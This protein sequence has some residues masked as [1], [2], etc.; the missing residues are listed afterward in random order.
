MTISLL[1][2]VV[3]LQLALVAVLVAVWKCVRSP[4]D[5]SPRLDSLERG[6]ERGE[7]LLREELGRNREETGVQIS[8]LREALS[9]RFQTFNDSVIRQM[10]DQAGVQTG[11]LDKLT[12]GLEQKLEALQQKVDE[13]LTRIQQDNAVR[14]EEMRKTVD[15]KLQGTLEKRLGES[16]RLVTEQL[17]QVHAG[18]GEMQTLASG[19]G[20]L[21]KVLTNVKTRGL[22]GEMQLGAL[23]EQV[24]APEQYTQNFRVRPD[25]NEVVEFA[26]RLPGRGDGEDVPVWLPIDA[27][28]PREDYERLIDASERGDSAAVQDAAQKIEQRIRQEAKDIS[29]K[30]IVPP[31]T[32]DFAILFLPVEGLY[33]EVLRRPGLV[34]AL[35]RLYR[36]NL[37]G[38][39][40]L[41]A[42]L[43]SLQM[44]FRTLAIQKR[45][46][47]V[48]QLLAA[49]KTEF[50][51]FG[52]V[53][54]GVQRKL[55]E[56]SNS[57]E[58]N[59]LQRTRA[60]N[61]RL[62]SVQDL[63]NTVLPPLMEGTLAETEPDT[64]VP[65]DGSAAGG[66]V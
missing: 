21:K 22:W 62:R 12:Q 14:L 43:N 31:L 20:D 40:T 58:K 44:G 65:S 8:A 10:A 42:L 23:L 13:K 16:F 57:I 17:K 30:Y 66:D 39:T 47:E 59:V 26:I 3:V 63:P 1:V 7:R 50:D 49:V 29:S 24:L 51:K 48:W 41:A 33:S 45:S 64:D 61:R 5:L 52:G 56:A 27:K 25:T 35:Q 36:V 60:I 18:L 32:T 28:Y 15:E 38:P 19:V 11:R 54:E 37:A 34:E 6:L 9:T 4:Q 53:I 55:Q 46:S 2:L